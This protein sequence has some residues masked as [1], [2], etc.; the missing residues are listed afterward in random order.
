MDYFLENHKLQLTQYE[1][2]HLNRPISIKTLNLEFKKD[3]SE[4]QLSR[5]KYFQWRILPNTVYSLFQKIEKEETLPI[6]FYEA[7]IIILITKPKIIQEKKT[8]DQCFSWT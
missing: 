2:D 5:S 6:S 3:K 4:K 7:N 8:T 1:T